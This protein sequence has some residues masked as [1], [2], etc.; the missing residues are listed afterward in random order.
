MIP[1]M[2]H[3]QNQ[4]RRAWRM[5]AALALGARVPA[6]VVQGDAVAA[7]RYRELCAQVSAWL[8]TSGALGTIQ[9]AILEI[10]AQQRAGAGR[11][12]SAPHAPAPEALA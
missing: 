2:A 7:A 6:H 5:R 11:A 12:S 10:E 8:R 3:Q 4:T 1:R 9:P